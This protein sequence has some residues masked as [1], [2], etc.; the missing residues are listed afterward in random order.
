MGTFSRKHRTREALV[1]ELQKGT[2]QEVQM[3][4]TTATAREPARGPLIYQNFV[5]YFRDVVDA[6]GKCISPK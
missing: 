6:L 5:R 1:A 3:S 4:M 2:V